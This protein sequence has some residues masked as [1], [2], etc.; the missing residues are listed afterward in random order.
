[1]NPKN[2]PSV[3]I[4][5]SNR[6]VGLPVGRHASRRLFAFSGLSPTLSATNFRYNSHDSN[7]LCIFARES[8]RKFL[9]FADQPLNHWYPGAGIGICFPDKSH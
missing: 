9:F 5:A 3:L 8:G 1:S 7:S 2:S 4:P 6:R